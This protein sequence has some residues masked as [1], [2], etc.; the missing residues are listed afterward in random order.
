MKQKN[1]TILFAAVAMLFLILDTKTCL[2]GASEGVELCIKT[3][4]QSLFPFFFLSA[5]LQSALS[6]QS[7]SF[8]RP[9]GKLCHIPSGAEHLLL[10]GLIGGYPVGAQAIHAAY[11]SGSLSRK[12]AERMLGF[13]SNAGPAFIF[14]MVGTLWHNPAM[15]WLLWGIQIMCA[16]CTGMLFSGDHAPV[17]HFTVAKRQDPMRTSLSAIATVSGWIILFRV[18]ITFLK[19]W[20]FWYFSSDTSTLIT[21]FLEL[22]NGCMELRQVL[23]PTKRFIMAAVFLSSGGLCVALQTVS[24]SGQLRCKN[25]FI[26]KT[27]QSLLAFV[28]SYSISG[29]WTYRHPAVLVALWAFIF[30]GIIVYHTVRKNRAGKYQPHGV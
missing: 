12:D 28:L 18:L 24:L 23:S 16:L 30:S 20:V 4:V 1:G 29:F 15:G 17:R 2:Q 25:Y 6:G 27:V 13:C 8:L 11:E 3:V 21:G 19:R 10:I 9:L 26:G 7:V 14:G 22:A 5:F